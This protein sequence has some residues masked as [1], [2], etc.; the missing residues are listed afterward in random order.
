MNQTIS[1]HFYCGD[2]VLA[3]EAECKRSKQIHSIYQGY[4]CYGK[5]MNKKRGQNANSGA[6]GAFCDL[7]Y[8]RP[9]RDSTKR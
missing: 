1:T 6:R 3:G 7:K 5:M 9:W 4:K 2:D 8:R